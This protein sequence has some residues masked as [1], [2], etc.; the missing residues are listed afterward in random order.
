[1]GTKKLIVFCFVR[2][3]KMKFF[4]KKSESNVTKNI[5]KSGDNSTDVSPAPSPQRKS[6]RASLPFQDKPSRMSVSASARVSSPTSFSSMPRKSSQAAMPQP[7][8]TEL[9]QQF[10][11]MMDKRGIKGPQREAMANLAAEQK[12]TLVCQERK[13]E[14]TSDTL[15]PDSASRIVADKD[16]SVHQI[17]LV[18]VSLSSQPVKW[19]S[20]FVLLV[21]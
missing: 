21:D 6:S 16:S 19:V 8:E 10:E 2:W 18:A 17:D 20:A 4:K 11:A 3:D 14:E 1:M 5:D 12:W 7:S 9:N 13:T 15:T